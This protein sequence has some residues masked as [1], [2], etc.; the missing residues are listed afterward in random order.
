MGILGANSIRYMQ[1]NVQAIFMKAKRQITILVFYYEWLWNFEFK[2]AVRMVAK[3]SR[4]LAS[5]QFC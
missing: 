1:K 3:G 2:R 4:L 5:C